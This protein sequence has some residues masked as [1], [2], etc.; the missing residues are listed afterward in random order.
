[1]LYPVSEIFTSLHGEG[2]FVGYPMAFVRLAG[3]S[4]ISCSIR[5]DCD[6]A[7]W[8]A[9]HHL[10]AGDIVGNIQARG[11]HSGIVCI[12]G[13]DRWCGYPIVGLD[14]VFTPCV[15]GADM[16]MEFCSQRC[17]AF[18]VKM[19]MRVVYSAAAA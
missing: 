4:I 6:E 12:S 8:K 13:G 14:P 19:P 2:H 17:A 16:W 1:M 9:K 15:G 7:P 3:C 10:R 18:V 11:F 5:N